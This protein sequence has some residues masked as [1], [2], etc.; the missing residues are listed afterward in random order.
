MRKGFIYTLEAVIAGIIVISL[1]AVFSYEPR[2]QDE[3][4]Y[5]KAY[6]LLEG[7]DNQ[8]LLRNYTVNEDY[9]GLDSEVRFFSANHSVQIC[10][11]SGSCVGSVPAGINVFSG[12]Y[13]IA[14]DDSYDPQYVKLYLWRS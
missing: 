6:E 8:G 9:T 13:I 2:I 5:L 1:L 14:G 10:D 7:L 12:T 4:L 11:R 3:G